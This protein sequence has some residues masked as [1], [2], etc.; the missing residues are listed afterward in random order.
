[1]TDQPD[2]GSAPR[3]SWGPP[4][5]Q[6]GA[7]PQWGQ[8]PQW[9]QQPQWDGGGA[10]TPGHEPS[11]GDGPP[12]GY[13]PAP[14]YGPPPGYG[15]GARP[16][17]GIVPLRPLGLGE[18]LDGAFQAIRTNPRTMLGVS[19]LVM[20]VVT[21]LGMVPQ[22]Y[23]FQSLRRLGQTSE[24][25]AF[26]DVA[27]PLLTSLGGLAITSLIKVLATTV[28]SALLVVAVGEAVIGRR[29]DPRALWARVR[30]RVLAVLG[31]SLLSLLIPGAAGL[32]GLV[33]VV[34]AVAGA[35][36]AGQPTGV[37]VLIGF[38]FGTATAV[39]V[40]W[41]AMQLA[42]A[43]PA[44][45][46][47]QIGVGAALRRSWRLVRGSWWRVFGVL[48]LTSII[49]GLGAG[50]VAVP[51]SQGGSLLATSGD[52]DAAATLRVLLGT[53]LGGIGEIVGGTVMTP[54][55]AAVTSLLYID[56]RM[57]SEG[58]DIE[59]SRAAAQPPPPTPPLG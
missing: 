25:A 37:V 42:L 23:L 15:S 16:R 17:P 14:G 24:T 33:A 56:R 48:L 20:I 52:P 47:E 43:G 26:E 21:G 13:G 57:R 36:A 11:P 10:T 38:L 54:F 59:L 55:S 39:L 8:P 31:V 3:P 44:L 2:H 30:P 9:G 18:I 40:V 4:A 41:L 50:I 6:G 32:A 28:L 53:V 5:H 46:L 35:D 27:G 49:A 29:I 7:S 58:L 12:P 34:A 51:F 1:M 22:F 45:L 19:A